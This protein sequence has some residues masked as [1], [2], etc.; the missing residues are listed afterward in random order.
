MNTYLDKVAEY[1]GRAEEYLATDPQYRK[2]IEL[3]GHYE[4]LAQL[5][6]DH[7]PGDAPEGTTS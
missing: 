1:L 7:I 5:E 6:Q 3:A 4:R 2:C